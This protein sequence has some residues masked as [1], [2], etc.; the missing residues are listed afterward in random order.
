MD[1]E[2]GTCKFCGAENVPLQRKY[3]YYNIDCECCG[4]E[5]YH[6]EIVKHCKDCTPRPPRIITVEMKPIEV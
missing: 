2:I 3:Y 1:I 5:G 6:F 4:K